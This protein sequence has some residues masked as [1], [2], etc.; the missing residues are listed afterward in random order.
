MYVC[1]YNGALHNR[2][3]GKNCSACVLSPESLCSAPFPTPAPLK[4]TCARVSGR[5]TL[6]SGFLAW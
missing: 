1:M 5:A 6:S 2:A 3:R 4:Y